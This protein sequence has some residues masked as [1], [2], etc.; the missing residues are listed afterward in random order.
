MLNSETVNA[1]D[2]TEFL[3]YFRTILRHFQLSGK[4]LALLNE[5]PKILE[6]KTIH[7]MIFCPTRMN[8]LL[9]VCAKL[10]K[11]VVSVCDVLTTV[12][13]KRKSEANS[14]LLSV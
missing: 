11:I 9:Q 6:L 7:M 3:P 14:Y 2:I 12:T 10:N 13:L 1:P 8:Y 4:S 5:S